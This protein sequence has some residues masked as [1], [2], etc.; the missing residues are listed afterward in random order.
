MFSPIVATSCVSSSA[1]LRPLPGIG[2][3][4]SSLEIV[5]DLE[6][7]LGDFRDEVLE[8]L[9]AGDEVGL[10]VD[11]DH[12]ARLAVGGDADQPFGGDA[13]GLLRGGGEA[14]LAQPVDRASRVACGLAPA[15]ACNPSCRRRSSRAAP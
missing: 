15:P 3:A 9:V 8:R 2:R 6:R 4:P 14:L 12:G 5:A 13:A 10:G 1:T 11:L 7:E